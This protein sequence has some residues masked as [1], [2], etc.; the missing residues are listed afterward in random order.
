M[1]RLKDKL[2]KPTDDEL[3]A[4]AL[5][6]LE[7]KR[8]EVIKR[9]ILKKIQSLRDEGEHSLPSRGRRKAVNVSRNHQKM[10]GH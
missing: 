9:Q 1:E 2:Q 4:L 6:V 10:T 8:D 7:N 5:R 3:I